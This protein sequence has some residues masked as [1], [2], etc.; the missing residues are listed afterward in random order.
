[1]IAIQYTIKTHEILKLHYTMRKFSKYHKILILITSLLFFSSCSRSLK[2]NTEYCSSNDFYNMSKIDAH[3]HIFSKNPDFLN[4]AEQDNFKIVSIVVDAEEGLPIP[5]QLS[6]AVLQKE[7]FPEDLSFVTSFTMKGW[8]NENW[9]KNT[10][11]F[12]KESLEK[13]AAGVKVWKN[14]GMVEKNK[15]G[16]FIMIDNIKFDPIFTFLEE[17][18]IPLIGHIG[19]PKN[20]WL[21]LDKMTTN[22]DRKYYKSHPQYH[23][24][25]H[26][27]YPSYDKLI[28]ARNKMLGKHPKLK[29]IGAH[30]ASVEWDLD[31]LS[32]LM[33]QFPN[34]WIDTAGRINHIQYHSTKN[35]QKVRNFMIKYQDR[36]LYGT[37]LGDYGDPN[38]HP[39]SIKKQSHEK[40][41][42]DWKFFTTEETMESNEINGKFTGLKLPKSIIEKIYY[43]NAKKLFSIN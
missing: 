1:M 42:A 2:N 12:L 28:S 39:D 29:F 41:V 19:E 30:L 11:S 26:P 23:M 5:E 27:E 32:L 37:D 33:E 31:E 25:L 18:N 13:G 40:W 34:L 6:L 9:Q 15:D 20:C 35:Y 21:P 14:I 7:K 43:K 17:N 4:Q 8:E 38:V 24:Y 36:I 3:C 10:L 22:S 16:T